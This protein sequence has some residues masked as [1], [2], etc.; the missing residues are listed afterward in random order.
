MGKKIFQ[1]SWKK[2]A[3]PWNKGKSL[4]YPADDCFFE[5]SC[6]KLYNCTKQNKT[7]PKFSPKFV[8][9]LTVTKVLLLFPK[10]IL[11]H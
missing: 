7:R 5:A 2:T 4:F 3:V 11:T 9:E 1:I 8:P 10:L 6:T